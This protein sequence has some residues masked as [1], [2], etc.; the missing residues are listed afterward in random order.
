MEVHHHPQVE[1][2]KFKEYFFEF[3]MIFLAVSMGFFAESLREQILDKNREKEYMKEI[4]ENLGYDSTRCAMNAE[5]N[6][7]IFLGL[8]SLR[9][10]LKEAIRGSVHG[11]RLYY[12]VLKYLGKTGHAVFNT[13]AITELK[14]S[15]SLRLIRNK[16]LVSEIADYYERKIFAAQSFLP[17]QA[18]LDALQ[19]TEYEFISLLD[20]DEYVKSYDDI[21]ESTYSNNYDL[22]ALLLRQ[23]DLRILKTGAPDLERFY[24]RVSE[25]EIRLKNYNF[26]LLYCKRAAV[27]LMAD[28]RQRG[29]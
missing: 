21:Q 5:T 23:P 18:Q 14:N 11:D 10:Q 24:T 9:N 28:I 26:W 6:A 22:A 13:S 4:V 8:D 7:Q 27:K 12:F 29:H 25:F 15:G 19:Q 20:L 16:E 3:L 17:T 1:K 2:K